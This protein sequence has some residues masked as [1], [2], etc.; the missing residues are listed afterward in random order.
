[1]LTLFDRGR[2]RFCDGLSRRNFLKIGGLALG[3]LSLPQILEA[4]AANGKRGSH[5]AI[6]MVFLPGGPPHQDMYDIKVDAPPEVRGEFKPI[7]TNV[8]GI[9]ICELLPRMA[10]MMDKLVPIRTIVG[11]D[12]SHY[13]QQCL[14]GWRGRNESPVQGG[15]PCLGSVLAKLK[16]PVDKAIPPFVG[17]SPKM[18]HM[19]WADPG[20]PGFLGQAYSPFKPDGEGM[21][22]MVLKGVTL[23]RLADRKQILASFDRFRADVDASGQMEGMDAFQKRAFDVLTSNKLRDALDIERE[24]P[25]LRDRY[26]RGFNENKS[27]G[28]PRNLDNFLVARRLVEAG[29]RCVTLAFSRWDWHGSNFGQARTEMPMLDQAVTALV[30][31]LEQRGMLDDVTVVVWGEFGRTPRINNNAGRDHWPQVSCALL[32]GGGMRTGQVIGSTN[33]LGEVPKDRPVHFQEV[34]ATLYHNLGI[35]VETTTIAD[36]AGRPQFLVDIREPMRELV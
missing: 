1:M 13:A 28:G 4:Q 15:R 24:D 29:V 17:L 33:R 31:D 9:E 22:N 25:K 18:G 36:H 2:S 21:E 32:A 6:I 34:F 11:A 3:G 30:E 23:D 5:K 12:G 20:Q 16:G 35:D 19:P 7:Q 26:G 8:A 10:G 27:D 14:S